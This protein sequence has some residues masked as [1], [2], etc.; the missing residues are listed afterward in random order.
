MSTG[1]ICARNCTRFWYQVLSI[2]TVSFFAQTIL[3]T[4]RRAVEEHS[5]SPL[6]L[7]IGQ[8]VSMFVYLSESTLV[9]SM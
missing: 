5:A 2:Q 9:L 7:H 3:D 8:P 1:T 4:Q 6:N